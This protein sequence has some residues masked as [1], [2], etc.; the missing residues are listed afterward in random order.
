MNVSKTVLYQNAM[1]CFNIKHI[2]K[3]N[4]PYEWDLCEKANVFT[5]TEPI[6]K[7]NQLKTSLLGEHERPAVK[8]SAHNT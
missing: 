5:S 3:K 7:L 8:P 2:L 6:N 1:F 4:D